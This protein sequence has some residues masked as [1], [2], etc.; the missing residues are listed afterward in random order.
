MAENSKFHS[1]LAVTNVKHLIPI[2]L[3]METGQYHSWATLFKVQAKVHSVLE[4]II[5]PTDAVAITAYQTAKVADLPLWNHLDV[6]VLQWIYV[7]ISPDILTSILVTDDSAERAWAMYLE[8]QFTNTCLTDFSSISAYCNHLKSLADQLSNVGAPFSDQR[9]VLRLLAGLTEAYASFVTVMQQKDELP[10]FATTCS[11]L[12]MEETTIKERAT[13]ESGSTTLLTV[14]EGFSSQPQHHNNNITSSQGHKNYNRGK[15]NN[16]GRGQ[17]PRWQR[18]TR[19]CL[20]CRR[21]KGWCTTIATVQNLATA[22]P[23]CPYPAAS[24][25]PRPQRKAA[26]SNVGYTPTDINAA[27]HNLSLSQ[28]DENWY[29]DTGAT[30]HMTADQGTLSSYFIRAKI[31]ILLLTGN[32]LMRC[33]SSGDLYPIPSKD[34][35]ISSPTFPSALTVLSPNLWHNRLGHPG[36]TILIHSSLPPSFW[37]HALQMATYLL[38][39]LPTKVLGYCSPTQVLY[40]KDPIYSHLRVFGCLCYPLFP[41]TTI[42][43][44][45]AR[46]TPCAFLG[47]PSH[48]RGYKCYDLL[49]GKIIISCHVIFDE[50]Q[51]PF[52]KIHD[53]SPSVYDPLGQDSRPP[54]P[55]PT[56]PAPTIQILASPN[57]PLSSLTTSHQPLV[58][59]PRPHQMTTRSQHGIVKPNPKYAHNLSTSTTTYI[60]PL[61]KNPVSALHELNWKSAMTDEYNALIKNKT[62]E[63]VP[64]PLDVNVFRSMWIFRHK[65]NSDGS[66][67]RHK[68]RLVGDGRSQKKGVYCDETFSPV[69]K[70]ATIRTV[71]SI[72]LSKSWPIHQLDVKNAFLHGTLNET[73]YMHQPMGFKD[74]S[75][76][77]YVCLLKKSL[78]GLKQAPRAWYKRFADHD[79]GPLSYFL[80][81]AVTR[82]ATGMFLSQKKYAEEILERAGMTN[83][84]TC[85]TPVDTKPKLGA[86]NDIP[87]E[88]PTKYRRL[89][90]ALQYLTLTRPDI[91]YAV[92]QVCLHMHDPKENHMNALKRILRYIQGTIDFGLHLYK[93]TMGNLL[94]YTDADWGGC[95]D[96]RRS[97]FGYCIFFGDNLISWS[98]KR[99]PTLSHSRVANVVS[100]SCW[101]Q[102]LLL[103]LH[104]PIHKATMVYCDNMSAIYLSGN[105]IQHQRTKHIEMDIHFVCEKV[106]RGEVRVLH[107]PSRY[108]I[109]DIFT[110]GLPRILFDDFRDSLSVSK[111]SAS[112]AG[113]Y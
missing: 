102:N 22:Q 113:V 8:T 68:A 13:R 99:Q 64:R 10:N 112:T 11:R 19:W 7:T 31:I 93:S 98:S 106:A 4:H 60:S 63:L 36:P 88:D 39:V 81:I 72:A 65:H 54:S 20:G 25:Q 6:V 57:T 71:L 91:S 104:C 15:K 96:T 50:T 37:H 16:R 27:M 3:D 92:Q 43:K 111:P 17:Q 49:S 95:P 40:R 53:P 62:W 78:Y 35:A 87:Y 24:W 9:L 90:G 77:D 85:P 86:S 48:H 89:A 103:E 82:N 108:Q 73:I 51:F 69:V 28:P 23:R 30:S 45:Q 74:S 18:W 52:S 84:K 100:E 110:K 97:T 59:N 29:M 80:G 33:N 79:L 21:W 94:S 41:T 66:F 14:D 67:E 5:P 12:K 70:S 46:S 105:P 44:L 75:H 55:Q 26:P 34:Q 107:V 1:A 38:N 101:I 32:H 61:P 76:P 83:C 2:T 47:Y 58:P 56:P 109:A 42:H